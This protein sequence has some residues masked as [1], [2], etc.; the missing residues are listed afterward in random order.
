MSYSARDTASC[1]TS[2][3]IARKFRRA[4]SQLRL[5]AG[6]LC[7]LLPRVELHEH[8][9]L[10]NRFARVERNAID[11]PGR[12]ALTVTP[13]TAATVPIAFSVAGHSS[14]A[15]TIVVTASG[16]GCI[17]ANCSAIAWNCLNFT[18]P[19]PAMMAIITTTIRIIRFAIR[20]L[21]FNDSAFQPATA[22]VV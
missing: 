5:G 21:P 13:C 2:P 16:G 19:R 7:L 17:A 15:A 12:S 14:A 20:L 1:S 6:Q 3:F 9:T 11:H 4:S 8:V 22:C 10:L 18:N